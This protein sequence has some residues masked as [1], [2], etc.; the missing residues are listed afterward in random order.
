MIENFKR[1]TFRMAAEKLNSRRAAE[2]LCLP[3]P[4]ATAARDPAQAWS[5]DSRG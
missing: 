3:Q 5:I 2:E 4:A 1:K